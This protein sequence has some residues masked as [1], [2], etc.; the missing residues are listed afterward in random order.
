MLKHQIII[1]RKF[2]QY[3]SLIKLGL[4]FR[5][6]LNFFDDKTHIRPYSYQELGLLFI[7]SDDFKILNMGSIYNKYLGDTLISYAIKE[8]D[9]EIFTYGMWLKYIWCDYI[10]L[11]KI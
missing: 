10:V 5:T 9:N 4:I 11:E 8:K 6:T 2:H 3:Q 7:K 1:L